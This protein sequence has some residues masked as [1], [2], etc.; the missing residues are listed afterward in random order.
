MKGFCL[1]LTMEYFL[2][3]PSDL[4]S[5]SQ[6]YWKKSN[7]SELSGSNIPASRLSLALQNT[8]AS[9]YLQVDARIA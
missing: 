2:F 9:D 7:M 1:I 3:P 6:L 4:I 5:N 8:A